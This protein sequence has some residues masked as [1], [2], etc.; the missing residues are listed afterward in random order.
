[1]F[2]RLVWFAV[3]RARLA[4]LEIDICMARGRV[5]FAV[6]GAQSATSE[7][8]HYAY[9]GPRSLVVSGRSAYSALLPNSNLLFDIL[10]PRSLIPSSLSLQTP[11]SS[12]I[13]LLPNS[14]VPS[15]SSLLTPYVI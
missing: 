14:L 6:A 4:T 11:G 5:L 12:S 3:A 13:S 15:N 2:R 10:F 8:A 1:M 7:I 9:Q